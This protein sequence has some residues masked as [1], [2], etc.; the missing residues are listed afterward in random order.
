MVSTIHI[1]GGQ[2]KSKPWNNEWGVSSTAKTWRC[3]SLINM[4][5][6]ISLQMVEYE[7]QWGEGSHKNH[8]LSP[9]V[10]CIL[11]ASPKIHTKCLLCR[12]CW[13]EVVDSNRGRTL[14]VSDGMSSQW[15]HNK[16]ICCLSAG[17][18]YINTGQ[19]ICTLLCPCLYLQPVPL[20]L[21]ASLT[22]LS[23][24]QTCLTLLPCNSSLSIIFLTPCEVLPNYQKLWGPSSPQS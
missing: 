3:P 21:K 19:T 10:V 13:W 23:P 20:A 17:T 24:T 11:N 15:T 14:R 1:L 16:N 9:A 12:R 4:F 8:P 2:S 6:R 18:G 22:S 5:P 7:T